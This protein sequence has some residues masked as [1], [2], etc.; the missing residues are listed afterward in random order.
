ML[1]LFEHYGHAPVGSRLKDPAV[2]V[3]V[4]CSESHFTALWSADPS[5]VDDGGDDGRAVELWYWDGLARQEEE[6][7]FT[8]TPP[9]AQDQEQVSAASRQREEEAA[10]RAAAAAAPVDLG[11]GTGFGGGGGAL[12]DLLASLPDVSVRRGGGLS[13]EGLG[14]PDEDPET[15]PPLHLVLRTRWAGSH[16][17]WNGAMPLL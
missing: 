1:T 4:V 15:A 2:P 7:H 3:W 10:R 9:S 14:E 5:V 11:F 8:V 17:S 6:I 12:G 16:I 13:G